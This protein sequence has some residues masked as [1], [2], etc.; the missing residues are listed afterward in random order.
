LCGIFGITKAALFVRRTSRTF[1]TLR[2]VVVFQR[3]KEPN[4]R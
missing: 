3:A 4:R 1:A 2:S